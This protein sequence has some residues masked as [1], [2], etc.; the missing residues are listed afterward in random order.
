MGDLVAQM[1]D[2]SNAKRRIE[3]GLRRIIIRHSNAAA[4]AARSYA[5]NSM[6]A[7]INK[8]TG[9]MRDSIQGKFNKANM[10]GIVY[11]VTELLKQMRAQRGNKKYIYYPAIL[12]YGTKNMPKRSNFMHR[13]LEKV[14]P[15]IDADVEKLLEKFQK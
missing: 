15:M 14:K 10:L 4:T 12:L 11:P 3:Y 7:K 8:R 13:A 2:S 6:P 9:A 5:Y 1:K